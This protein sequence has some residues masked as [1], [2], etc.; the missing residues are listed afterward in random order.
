MNAEVQLKFDSTDLV[1]Q[2]PKPLVYATKM[3]RTEA[4]ELL[5]ADFAPVEGE[6]FD[7]EYI[8]RSVLYSCYINEEMYEEAIPHLTRMIE[9]SVSNAKLWSNLSGCYTRIGKYKEAENCIV[10]AVQLD[11]NSRHVAINLSALCEIT[12]NHQWTMGI[13]EK[14]LKADPEDCG[15]HYQRS[16]ALLCRGMLAEGFEEY[17]WRVKK[18]NYRAAYGYFKDPLWAGQDLEGKS[19]LIWTEQGLGDETLMLSMLNDINERAAFVRVYCSPRMKKLLQR[20]F[21]GVE[22]IGFNE[23]MDILKTQASFQASFA[24]LGL[25]LRPTYESFPKAEAYFKADPLR[26]KEL[27]EKYQSMFPGD[28]L[29]GISWKS[30]NSDVGDFKSISLDLWKGL[31]EAQ[32]YHFVSLQYGKIIGGIENVTIDESIDSSKDMDDFAAQVSAMDEVI[33]IS[34]TTAHFAGALGVKTTVLVPRDRGKL[35]YWFL[36]ATESIWYKDVRILRQHAL[37]EWDGVMKQLEVEYK[38]C[39]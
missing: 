7:V 28:K 33:T 26:T 20:S 29:I 37:G 4:F 14:L 24:E 32:G 15:A 18:Y 13:Y 3:D 6:P 12:G 11:P 17:K 21:P 19:V 25:H 34:N 35:W 38:L 36:E 30:E 5:N 16:C 9:L 2:R 31:L 23:K 8:K 1:A 27:R 22:F 10:M 39:L